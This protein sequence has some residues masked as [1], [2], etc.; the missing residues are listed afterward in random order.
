MLRKLRGFLLGLSVF[1]GY[2]TL[3]VGVLGAGIWY[4]TLPT[5]YDFEN[6]ARLVVPSGAVSIDQREDGN[7]IV[8][9]RGVNVTVYNDSDEWRSLTVSYREENS[10]ILGRHAFEE[11]PPKSSKTFGAD[12]DLGFVGMHVT[13]SDYAQ[14]KREKAI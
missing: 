13:V 11:L 12:D 4:V 1:V 2:A 8:I 3:I 9:Q 14:R 7:G 6:G 10:S 5:T